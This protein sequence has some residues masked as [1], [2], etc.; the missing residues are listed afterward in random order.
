MTCV[1]AAERITALVDGELPAAEARL[2]EEHLAGCAACREARAAEEGIAARLRAAPRPAL[3]AGFAR[4][5]M[6]RVAS[7]PAPG[8][9]AS[10]GEP[11]RIL[12]FAPLWVAAVAV[13]AAVVAMVIVGPGGE[14]RHLGAPKVDVASVP[15]PAADPAARV[16]GEAREAT[17]A[18]PPESA[19]LARPRDGDADDAR[20]RAPAAPAAPAPAPAAGPAAPGRQEAK[21]GPANPAEGAGAAAGDDGK[22]PPPADATKPGA[23][24]AGA[25]SGPAPGGG[26]GGAVGGL[27]KDVAPAGPVAG[28]KAPE[29]KRTAGGEREKSL[30]LAD[31]EVPRVALYF[32]VGDVVRGQQEVER[33]IQA[34]GEAAAGRGTWKEA[35]AGEAKPAAKAKAEDGRVGADAAATAAARGNRVLEI[36]MRAAD[37]D[38][39]RTL[40]GKTGLLREG[41]LQLLGAGVPGVPAPAPGATP[42]PLPEAGGKQ[43]EAGGKFDRGLTGGAGEP[44][45]PPAP[46]AD[47]LRRMAE[48]LPPSRESRDALLGVL[49]AGTEEV[50]VEIHIQREAGPGGK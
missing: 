40:L 6:D 33:S 13:A 5:V 38:R 26:G 19:V 39:L 10:E 30:A 4:G 50:V 7:A 32:A 3:P 25:P 43:G 45:P 16:A 34:L 35:D 27:R 42:A 21:D 31:A 12:P 24:A 47:Q 49:P 2:L 23:A 44:V 41:G 37:V 18:R 48:A 46:T 22:G 36:R 17:D 11:A 28:A 15:T 9:A 29:E 20:A 1:D 8:E 14:V